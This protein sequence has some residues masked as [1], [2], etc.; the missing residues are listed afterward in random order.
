MQFETIIYFA[1]RKPANCQLSQALP[2][3]RAFVFLKEGKKMRFVIGGHLG[4][5][6][7]LS[8]LVPISLPNSYF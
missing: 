2:N 6:T 4:G 7:L 8:R 3:R 1:F 5:P